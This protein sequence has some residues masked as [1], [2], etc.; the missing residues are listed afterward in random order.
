MGALYKMKSRL[1]M[2]TLVFPLMISTLSISGCKNAFDEFADKKTDDALLFD[3][4]ALADDRNWTAAIAKIGQMTAA[5]QADRTTKLALASFYAGRCGLDLLSL[6]SDLSAGLGGGINLM[7]VLSKSRAGSVIANAD[8]CETAEKTIQ[9]ISLAPASRTEDE[10]VI[11][12]MIEFAKLGAVLVSSGVDANGDGVIDTNHANT[13]ALTTVPGGQTVSP[14]QRI[15]AALTN[16]IKS[17]SASGSTVGGSSTATMNAM[18]TSLD[19]AFGVGFCNQFL[20]TNFTAGSGKDDAMAALI[21]SNE[22]GYNL[23][24]GT[25]MSSAACT[26]P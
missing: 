16:A 7:P 10:N 6:A 1:L 22:I 12:A 5:G 24:G 21:L 2:L 23:C 26:C 20:P 13:C 14:A 19:S 15:G 11:L 9:S 8:D 4:N 25:L 3:A 17:L 18:C